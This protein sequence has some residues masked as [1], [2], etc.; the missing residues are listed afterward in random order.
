[1]IKIKN[2][3]HGHNFSGKDDGGIIYEVLPKNDVNKYRLWRKYS[4]QTGIK[5]KKAIIT[6]YIE[7]R[8]TGM[9]HLLPG[10]LSDG[11][12]GGPDTPKAMR[13]AFIHDA[14]CLLYKRGLIGVAGLRAEK[15]LQEINDLFKTTLLEDK[16]KSCVA[17]F[18]RACLRIFWKFHIDKMIKKED[19]KN[20][21]KIYSA[22]KNPE[23]TTTART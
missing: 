15:Y 6:K 7:L 1:M 16:M 17:K 19:D 23:V 10:L 11:V 8:T 2:T 9:L 4:I 20:D 3:I 14:L 5:P 18:Y 13:G 12:T 22:I 21:S